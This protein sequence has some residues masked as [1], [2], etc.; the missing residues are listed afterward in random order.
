MQINAAWGTWGTSI[1]NFPLPRPESSPLDDRGTASAEGTDSGLIAALTVPAQ[2]K[3]T[4]RP[5]GL[6]GQ[7]GR[8]VSKGIRPL[9]INSNAAP[10][11]A[12]KAKSLPASPIPDDSKPT[13]NGGLCREGN[14]SP[15]Q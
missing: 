5:S 10:C 15:L 9:S 11:G 6:C 2:V 12:V 3:G 14:A 13:G 4:C 7:A 1:W 8:P